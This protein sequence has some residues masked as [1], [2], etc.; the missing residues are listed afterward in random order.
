MGRSSHID[1]P[2]FIPMKKD[3]DQIQ[4]IIDSSLFV[5]REIQQPIPLITIQGKVI[6]TE[7]NFI[8]IS[9]LPKSRKTTFQQLFIASGLIRDQLMQ[10][11]TSLQKDEKIVL[12]DTEQG[13]YDFAKQNKYLK[14]LIGKAKNPKNFSAYLFREYDPEIILN[15]I[16]MIC[17]KEKPKL[18]F[19]DNLTE[20]AINPNDIAEA[21]KIIQ[22]L[23]KIT[24]Q[25]N[26]GI[27]CLLHLAK[28]N[29][30]TLGNLGSY[31][32][33]A[34]QSVLK[35]TKDKDS[36]I[37][38]LEALMLRS[39]AHF[40]PISITYDKDSGM[41]QEIDYKPPDATKKAKFS[42]DQF[43]PSDLKA[44][45]QI[46]FEMQPEYTYS[47]LVENLKKLFGVGN[48]IIKQ[49]VIPYLVSKKYLRAKD[50]IYKP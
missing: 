2:F 21:K 29:N 39:D 38:T 31:A 50:S 49:M 40:E 20:L 12:V 46:L 13:I 7:G 22:F 24:A 45:M 34:A 42:M 35:V 48:N 36:D 11:S 28:S 16:Y 9:G 41:Y 23:K 5:D 15:S 27:V 18:I 17:E 3:K 32:D 43:T 25:F 4:Q 33:R 19:I 26:V 6:L 8:T 37:S 44:R 30:F 14:K 10:I 47:P 1:F